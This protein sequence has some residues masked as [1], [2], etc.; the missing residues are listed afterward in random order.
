MKDFYSFEHFKELL[1][2]ENNA[3]LKFLKTFLKEIKG[4]IPPNKLLYTKQINVKLN[5]KING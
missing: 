4:S 1:N 3:F 2:Q 5:L